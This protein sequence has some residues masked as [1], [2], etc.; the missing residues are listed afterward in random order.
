MF[1]NM[2]VSTMLATGFGIVL[3]ITIIISVIS[4]IGLGTAVDG[5]KDY[6]G[7]ARDTNLAGRVQANML[8]VRLYVK[9]FFKTGAKLSVENYT[10]RMK[11]S[12]ELAML[13]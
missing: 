8:M 1:K 13:S 10:E 12:K 3:T 2:K 5:F 6:R 7:L 9:D 11:L 4:F